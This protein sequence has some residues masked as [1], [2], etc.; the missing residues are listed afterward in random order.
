MEREEIY[1]NVPALET[2][3]LLLRK[4]VMEDAEDLFRYASEPS[5]SRFMP[6]D[7]HKTIEETKGFLAFILDSYDQYQKLTWAIELKQT[8]KMIGTIDYVSWQPKRS[9]AEIAYT[10]SHEYW[11]QGLM[12]EAADGLLAFG[13]KEMELNK[14]EAP[15][16]LENAQSR[17]LAEKLGMKLEGVA[18]DHMVIK[19]E[20]VDLA[21]YSILK[22]EF[23]AKR[24]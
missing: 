1:R 4:L 14:I 6:W 20:F 7:V 5:V 2:E 19:G 16:M 18:R 15:I 22:R 24:H 8:G 13:F 23:S 9:K 17:R 10:L 12:K 3:R 21:M 11:G